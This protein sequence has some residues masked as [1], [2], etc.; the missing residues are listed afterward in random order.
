MDIEILEKARE[1][2]TLVTKDK[3]MRV[4]AKQ[5]GIPVEDYK[6]NKVNE[7]YK[8]H[9]TVVWEN[10]E[11]DKLFGQGY[12]ELNNSNFIE[13]EFV[14]LKN[15]QKSVLTMHRNGELLLL[16]TNINAHGIKPKNKEQI[17]AFNALM[18]KEIELVTMTGTSGT[19]KT[20][21]AIANGLEQVLEK[22]RYDKMIV[23]RPSVSA[24]EE[25]G[26]LPG[27]IDEKLEP[28]MK[29]IKDNIDFI[30]RGR[31]DRDVVQDLKTMGKLEFESLE[32]IRGRSIP[33]QF[34]LIDEVQN[35]D[36]NLIKTILTR[37][38]KG[39]KI[40]L[41]GDIEQID[42][43]YLDKQSNGLSYVIDKFKGQNNFAQINLEKSERSRLA[44]QSSKLL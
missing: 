14:N 21:C 39:S 22:E 37:V 19:G 11:I 30:Y 7:V 24:G 29:P 18:N 4:I 13:N 31:E 15:G 26:F 41:T 34:I 35:S 16:D 8:G 20:M 40:V 42:L 27:N 17:F 25:L 33:N 6:N 43:P 38:G 28:W 9:S 3:L 10:D 5:E 23:A 32:H 2:G 1:Y 12:L 44:E 36:I